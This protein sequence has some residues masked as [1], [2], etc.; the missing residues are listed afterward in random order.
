MANAIIIDTNVLI[1]DP[2]SI[3]TLIDTDNTI[4]I[5]YIVLEELD[6]LKNKHDIG[7]DA[8]EAIKNIH[9]LKQQ[10]DQVLF[11]TPKNIFNHLDYVL[12][13]SKN[14]HNIILCAYTLY[15]QF[16][17]SDKY[18]K[19]KLISRDLVVR[20]LADSV[21][22]IAETYQNDQTSIKFNTK[23]KTINV[24]SDKINSNFT[25][26][27]PKD[28]ETIENGGIVC[29]SNWHGNI[30]DGLIKDTDYNWEK[31]F[32]AIKKKDNFKILNNENNLFGLSPYSSTKEY[33]YPQQLAIEQLTDKSI[34]L[35]FLIGCSGSGKTLLSLAAALQQ[36][37]DYRNIIV[38]RPMVH[39]DDD[40]NIGYLP[41]DIKDK[42]DP[43]LKPVW[44]SLSFL[45]GLSM[46]NSKIIKKI[47]DNNKIQIEPLNYIRGNTFTKDFI[48]VDEAQNLTPHQ[49]K[50][51][52]TRCGED[53]K[54]VFTG[55]LGQIDKKRKL[56]KKSNGLVYASSKLYNEP[57]VSI[58]FFLDTVR[59]DLAKLA[60]AKL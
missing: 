40:D 32:T 12:D 11:C 21:G 5:P 46:S 24:H 23:L 37:K 1:H 50:T 49:I 15:D 19:I 6:G 2:K 17:D 28:C 27:I 53:S 29:M 47:K 39:L 45:S 25:F 4:Y 60:E 54:I 43:W 13:V 42:M 52:I 35:C 34:K 30:N 16:K 7:F 14:D 57:L 44:K 8:R 56:D 48:I 36:R 33:N 59:S 9:K 18:D 22:L 51:I 26:S 20:I 38:T 3:E 58:N 10:T 55:D 31:S 41:G